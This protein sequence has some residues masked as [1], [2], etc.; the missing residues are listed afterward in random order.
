MKSRFD[1][2][3]KLNQ[4]LRKKSINLNWNP[5]ENSAIRGTIKHRAPSEC[6]ED[7][8]DIIFH[9]DIA[10]T[11]ML[12]YLEALEIRVPDSYQNLMNSFVISSEVIEN[13]NEFL[14][15]VQA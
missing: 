14:I 4:L 5:M 6:L 3:P 11:C 13:V 1:K 9:Y 10:I 2:L 12:Q 8:A 15:K 7:I